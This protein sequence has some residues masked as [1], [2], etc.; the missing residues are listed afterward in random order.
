MIAWAEEKSSVWNHYFLYASTNRITRDIKDGKISPWL[1][2]NC[3]TGKQA[4]GKFS[5]EQ[6]NMISDVIN[7]THWSLKFKRHPNDVELAKI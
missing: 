4:L 7:P 2:L 3:K 1:I 6:L 5:D